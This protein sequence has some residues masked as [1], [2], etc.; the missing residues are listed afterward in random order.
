MDKNALGRGRCAEELAEMLARPG[1]ERHRRVASRFMNSKNK[2][3]S[4]IAA[5]K[6]RESRET[7]A[8]LFKKSLCDWEL[9]LPPE[10]KSR[11]LN[12]L[13]GRLRKASKGESR[14]ED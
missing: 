5:M 13:T 1:N 12:V 8:R 4:E 3:I 6:D 7:L 2:I 11:V 9:T 10:L 14:N